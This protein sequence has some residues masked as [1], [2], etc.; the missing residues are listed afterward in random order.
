VSGA[1]GRRRR[2]VLA[3]ASPARLATLRRAGVEPEVMVSG[4]DEDAISADTT[5]ELVVALARAKAEVVADRVGTD[6]LVLGCDSMLDLGGRALGKPGTVAAAI[7]RWQELRG[8][9][10]V[11]HTGHCLIDTASGDLVTRDVGTPVRFADVSDDEIAAYCGTGEP[12]AV[13]GAF[14]IDGLGGW[15]VDGVDGDPHN[16]VGV[17]LPVVRRMLHDLGHGLHTIGYPPPE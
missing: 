3:S 5:G 1:P 8:R 12:T 11:L 15:F 13:A 7:V 14:T 4:V 16:V 6:A 2:F 17:S 9:T 10:G